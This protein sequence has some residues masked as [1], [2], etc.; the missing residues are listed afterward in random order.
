MILFT[1]ESYFIGKT[2]PQRPPFSKDLDGSIRY[3]LIAHYV[4][5]RE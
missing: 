2:E 4:C 3:Q 5:R 1:L